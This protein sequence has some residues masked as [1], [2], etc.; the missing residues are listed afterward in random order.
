MKK[1]VLYGASGLAREVAM[2]IEEI[3]QI[4][5]T[6]ELLGFVSEGDHF[7][8]GDLINGY[9]WLGDTRWIIEHKSDVLC[10]VAIGTA[11]VKARIQREL[12]GEGVCF[13]T[14][15]SPQSAVSSHAKIGEGCIFYRNITVSVNTVIGDGVLLITG[16]TVGHDT[17][18]GDYTTVMTCTGISGFCQIGSEVSIGGHAYIVPHKKVGDKAT[19]AA[20]SVVFSNVR[21]G[22]TVLGNPA[23]RMRELEG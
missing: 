6:Y 22:T 23:K 17:V 8:P 14:I 4:S 11:S 15:A 18:I 19:I 2:I 10:N 12:K 16:C 5:P 20:G 7:A 9:P 3:N 21:A 1:I 13:E